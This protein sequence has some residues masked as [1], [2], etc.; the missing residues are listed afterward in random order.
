MNTMNFIVNIMAP[1]EYQH[2]GTSLNIHYQFANTPF[3]NI[4]I[5]S[6]PM[7]ICHLMFEDDNE[8]A[9][10]NLKRRFP[11]ASYKFTTDILQQ[12]ALK[13]FTQNWHQIN[14]I[15]LHLTGTDFQ[16]KVWRSLLKIPI[17]HLQTYGTIAKTI[18]QPSAARAVGTAIGS[19]TIAFLIPCHRVMQASG[20]LGGYR[21]GTARKSSLLTWEEAQI[22]AHV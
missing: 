3:G 17:G 8:I 20:G 12:S 16:L 13:V 1:D 6:T 21:W 15:K 9:I 14:S 22:Q 2:G 18:N 4:I 5:A 11:N 7:G 10:E 19:N